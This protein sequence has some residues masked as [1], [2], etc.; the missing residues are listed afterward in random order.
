MHQYITEIQ[1]TFRLYLHPDAST[2]VFISRDININY[3]KH[4][5]KPLHSFS[6]SLLFSTCNGTISAFNQGAGQS[7]FTRL[8]CRS[9]CEKIWR[10]LLYLCNNRWQWGWVRT[11]AGMDVKRFCELGLAG[12]ELANDPSLLGAGRNPGT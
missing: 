10:Y 8:F 4:L 7:C 9:N 5:S 1:V 6:P 12:Y 3:E 11:I 2:L